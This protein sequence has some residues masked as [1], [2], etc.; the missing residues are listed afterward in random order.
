MNVQMRVPGYINFSGVHALRIFITDL[1]VD[2]D[3]K[4]VALEA[5]QVNYVKRSSFEFLN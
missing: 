4:K 2:M 1:P 3:Q 5:L